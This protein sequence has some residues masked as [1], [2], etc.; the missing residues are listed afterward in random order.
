MFQLQLFFL[1]H[2]DEWNRIVVLPRHKFD[3]GATLLQLVRVVRYVYPLT[4]WA[5][6]KQT[7][8]ASLWQLTCSC[9]DIAEKLLSWCYNNYSLNKINMTTCI[10]NLLTILFFTQCICHFRNSYYYGHKMSSINSNRHYTNRFSYFKQN[11][12]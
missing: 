6:T 3:T 1:F 8:S 4:C 5:S 7:S 2:C 12:K 9:H 10:F 11:V